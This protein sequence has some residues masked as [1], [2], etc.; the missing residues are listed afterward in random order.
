MGLSGAE[1]SANLHNTCSRMLLDKAILPFVRCQIRI[2]VF[3]LLRGDKADIPA[4]FCP[5]L[6]IPYMQPV[7]GVA[8]GTHNGT[9]NEL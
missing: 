9:D 6:R 4:E 7:V 3:Q 8:D 2:K 1:L 5:K